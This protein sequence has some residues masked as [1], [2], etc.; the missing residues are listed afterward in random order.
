MK[1]TLKI[2]VSMTLAL[3]MLIT[4]SL[5]IIAPEDAAP[6]IPEISDEALFIPLD[7][8]R[9]VALLFLDDIMN[10]GMTEWNEQ[11][12]VTNVVTLYDQF[13]GINAYSVE[14]TT[15]YVVVAAYMDVPNVILEWSD[16]AVPL[17]ANFDITPS[18]KIVYLGG[19][20][21]YKKN[22]T[23]K[24][25]T[26]DDEIVESFNGCNNLSSLRNP[27]NLTLEQTNYFIELLDDDDAPRD[28][29]ILDPIEHANFIYDDSFYCPGEAFYEDQWQL[30]IDF[31][32]TSQFPSYD[33]HCGP[34]AIANILVAFSNKYMMLP[35]INSSY[36]EIFEV[37]A[38]I[39]ITNGYYNNTTY[40]STADE[41]IEACFEYYDE[42]VTISE[43]KDAT[44][45]NYVR[46]LRNG[47]LLYFA[48]Y[49]HG[50]YRNHS[51]VCYGYITLVSALSGN[52]VHYIEIADGHYSSPRYMEYSTFMN[53]GEFYEIS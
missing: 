31:L 12:A 4:P 46:A 5:A 11:T 8:A 24:L 52:S 45:S 7:T 38:N 19:I 29:Y 47:S 48:V 51:V 18:E 16:T 30:Y 33:N 17:Y 39:G 10:T 49:N 2:A 9:E 15:G 6:I 53:N 27:S 34:T 13:G 42:T 1:K 35:I 25:V 21:Y 50:T 26:V 37:V 36:D 43:L 3:M 23:L 40:T 22:D 20:E 28:P 32:V 41:Y 14:L 44:Y